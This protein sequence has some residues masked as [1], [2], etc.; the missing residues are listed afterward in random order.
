MYNVKFLYMY[1][2]NSFHILYSPN[3]ISFTVSFHALMHNKFFFSTSVPYNQFDNVIWI[4]TVFSYMWIILSPFS[5]L[6]SLFS[7]L[8][9]LFSVFFIFVNHNLSQSRWETSEY[10]FIW[11]VVVLLLSCRCCCE[12]VLFASHYIGN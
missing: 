8:C 9:F 6:C 12:N 7:V 1:V 5:V 11:T 4:F 10:S 2:F 3:W